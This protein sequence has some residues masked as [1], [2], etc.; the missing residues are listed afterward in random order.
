MPCWISHNRP[1]GNHSISNID[2]RL[3]RFH[4]EPTNL[5]KGSAHPPISEFNLSHTGPIDIGGMPDAKG[6]GRRFD[7]RDSNKIPIPGKSSRNF[8]SL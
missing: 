4:P 5:H 1:W 7:H 2:L 8:P 3:E 6:G